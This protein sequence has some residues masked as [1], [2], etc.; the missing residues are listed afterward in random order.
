MGD[1]DAFVPLVSTPGMM[2]TF[3]DTIM[4]K[5]RP[6]DRAVEVTVIYPEGVNVTNVQEL[7]EKAWRSVNKTIT[8]NSV[9]VRR[10]MAARLL[11]AVARPNRHSFRWWG[12]GLQRLLV[13]VTGRPHSG[14]QIT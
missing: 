10:L 7:A 9:T 1:Q 8:I 3:K 5:N 12:N 2:P 11:R 13:V 4:I 6:H 14:A